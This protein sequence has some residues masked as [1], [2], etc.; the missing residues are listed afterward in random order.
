MPGVTAASRVFQVC[1]RTVF[2]QTPLRQYADPLPQPPAHFQR[3]PLGRGQLAVFSAAADRPV[4]ILTW[5]LYCQ[6]GSDRLEKSAAAES[7]ATSP[8]YGGGALSERFCH[9]PHLDVNDS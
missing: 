2:P 8:L 1:T 3:N 5:T 9:C 6:S 7:A 4:L